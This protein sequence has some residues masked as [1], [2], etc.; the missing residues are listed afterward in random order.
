MFPVVLRI[1]SVAAQFSLVSMS[2]AGFAKWCTSADSWRNPDETLDL[3]GEDGRAFQ[4]LVP[5]TGKS[6]LP[7]R[8]RVRGMSNRLVLMGTV[9]RLGGRMT[10]FCQVRWH[11]THLDTRKT[12]LKRWHTESHTVRSRSLGGTWIQLAEKWQHS[13]LSADGICQSQ[14]VAVK[15]AANESLHKY[16]DCLRRMHASDR[17]HKQNW[18]KQDRLWFP[19]SGRPTL[20]RLS[21]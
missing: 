15:S 12:S 6:R 13:A 3:R 17:Q 2:V 4:V 7:Q 20:I 19:R 14:A 21:F 10:H 8:T 1:N 9:G 5:A 11:H 16:P 18:K